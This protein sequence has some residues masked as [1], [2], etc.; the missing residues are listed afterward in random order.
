MSEE[1]KARH[2]PGYPNLSDDAAEKLLANVFEACQQEP[3]TVPLQQLESYSIY[4]RERY[5]VQKILL[6]AVM[7][8]FLN[9][10]LA[11]L[12]PKLTVEKIS[13][14]DDIFP[15]YQI[16]VDSWLPVRLVA[17]SVD[18]DGLTVTETAAKTYVT[19]PKHDGKMLV[20]V[21]L[22]N[23]QYAI[24][25]VDV[26]GI[27]ATAPRLLSHELTEDY[28]TITL[29]DEGTGIDY[30]T[31]QVVKTMTGETVTPEIDEASNTIRIPV[32]KDDLNIY[33]CD[34]RGNEL[35]LVLTLNRE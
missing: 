26:K 31:L 11:F 3:N 16:K 9:L 32:E 24:A 20:S 28:I 6:I 15:Q 35:Q 5:G 19:T 22:N 7:L 30:S 33:V 1:N 18:G 8:I 10:P 23:R 14:E 21:T 34:R 17:A 29:V 25:E 4:R 12:A 27:D 13:A 2:N